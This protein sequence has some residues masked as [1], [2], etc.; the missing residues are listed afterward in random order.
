MAEHIPL[1]NKDYHARPEWSHSQAEV[2]RESP[3]LFY[4]RYISGEYPREATPALDDG[5]IAHEA[6]LNPNGLDGVVKIIPADVLNSQGHR[7]GA[8]WKDWAADH[9]D[10]IHRKASEMD[11]IMRMIRSACDEPRAGW[12][13]ELPGPREFSIFWRDDESGLDLRARL[14]IIAQV[15]SNILLR[16]GDRVILCDFKTT[17]SYTPYTFARDAAQYGYHRQAAWYWDAA[18]AFGLDV[19]DFCL[20]TVDKT[21]AHECRV[22]S[23]GEGELLL[24]REQNQRDRANLAERLATDNW[25]AATHGTIQPLELPAWAFREL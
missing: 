3:P 9:A 21:P 2:L 22:K 19:Q 24:G 14:D 16:P 18:V 25:L 8:N 13:L 10:F 5:T 17:R 11:T 1:S 23:I 12:L 6:L 7:K 4:G 20:V 15:E